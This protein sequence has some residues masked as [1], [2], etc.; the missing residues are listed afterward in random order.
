M[1][2]NV[3]FHRDFSEDAVIEAC[4]LAGATEFIKQMDRG[5]DQWLGGDALHLSGGERQ[6]IGLARALVG[7]PDVLISDEA[8][9]AL[10]DDLEDLVL[11]EIFG[12]Y[13]GRTIILITHRQRV[14]ENIGNVIRLQRPAEPL[15]YMMQ[16][17]A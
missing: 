2:D 10:G 16:A 7:H 12:A 4:R 14:T 13:A 6:R 15:Q 17:G 3:L 11:A 5:Y 9:S 8:T 1:T